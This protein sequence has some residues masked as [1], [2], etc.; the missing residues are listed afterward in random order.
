[1]GS[2]VTEQLPSRLFISYSRKNRAQVYPFAEALSA[3]GVGVWIDL[4][5][6]DP[7]DDFPVR[8]RE[9]IAQCHALLAWYSPEYSRSTYCQKEL[10]A[11]WICAQRLTRNALSRIL[12]INPADNVAHI[13]LGDLG[14]QNYLTAPKNVASQ[15]ATI[16]S[17]QE[18]LAG[19]SG[20]FA[21]V[22]EFEPPVW[23]PEV[24]QGSRRFVGR[25]REL[26]EIHT[27]FNS[28]G[29]SEHENANG[30]AQLQGLGGVGKTLLA[31]EYAKRFSAAYPGGIHWLR[32]YGF[33]PKKSI[34]TDLRESEYRIQLENI[35]LRYDI[36]IRDKEFREIRRDLG[37]KLASGAPYLWVVDDLPAGLNLQEA[38]ARWCA[39][40]PNGCTLMTTRTK[41]YDGIGS[42]ITVDVLDPE[43]ALELLTHERKAQTIREQEDAK[44]LVEAL[45]RHSLAL[46]VAGHFLLR[47]RSFAT[48]RREVTW[49]NETDPFGVL[50][51]SLKGQLPGGHEK[52]IVATLLASVRQ[53]SEEGLNL[54][55]LA[56]ELQAG[57]PIPLGLAKEVFQRA[58]PQQ[59][60]EDYLGRAVNQA[61]MHSLAAVSYGGA[62]G[63]ALSV[64]PLVRYTMRHGD[65]RQDE[66]L[67][68]RIKLREAAVSALVDLLDDVGDIRKHTRLTLEITHA[69]NLVPKPHTPDEARL[70]TRVARFEGERGNYSEA[71]AIESRVLP[72]HELLLGRDHPDTLITRYNIA[73]WTGD[74]RG[75]AEPLRQFRELLHDQQR[76]LGLD[77]A[78][79]LRTRS[80][81]AS[82]TARKG[83]AVEALRLFRE[84][85]PNQ[86]R[87][88]GYD[89]PDTL[90][91]RANIAIWIGH[92]GDRAEALRL[93]RE[94]LPDQE[95]V[96]GRDHPETLGTRA[97]IATWIGHTGDSAEALRQFRELLPDREQVLG[98]DHPDM[99]TTR[100]QIAHWAGET[101]EPVEALRQFRELLP[102]QERVLGCDHPDA[103]ATRHN[104][105][106]WTEHTGETSEA[107]RLFQELLPKRER[108]LGRDHPDT[109]RTLA[110][111]AYLTGATGE[112]AEGLRL[113]RELLP[114]QEQVR[115]YDHPDTLAIHN[116]IAALTLASGEAA[117]ALRLFRELL[118]IQ[119][120][121]LGRDHPDTLRTRNNIATSTVQT[122]DMAEAL[123]LS[124]ELLS[125]LE[126]VVGHTHPHALT[127]RNN[128]ATWTGQMGETAEALRL[129]R[130]LLPER[131]RVLGRDHPDTRTTRANIVSLE[132]RGSL[133]GGLD[134]YGK[135]SA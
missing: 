74:A 5:E 33:D 71:L 115:G 57:T 75:S 133:L 50:A 97:D 121:V 91:T 95:R 135:P 101:G 76:V 104:I 83:D 58:F 87:V 129:F 66:A 38:F 111:I 7:L 134:P 126:R 84:L 122:G 116:N 18:K 34:D 12:I 40:S 9:G 130:E 65:P 90:R 117:K 10:T 27:A 15:N 98:R 13:A 96:L 92:T 44:G 82:W 128:I 103:L 48:L 108:L 24:Q 14:K 55:R 80:D 89:H 107:L 49:G 88:L 51:E 105:A 35:A 124:R 54:L 131:E 67:V 26:W 113:F 81:I 36:P 53:L 63:D 3:A 32:A 118:P 86:E 46:D 20:D 8:I 85:L 41:D 73:V 123:R 42:T 17:I 37:R 21:A 72:I 60:A 110:N 47:T 78:V 22:R 1:M 132:Q 79:A 19:L 4:E 31:T 100:A 25:L 120:R 77:H 64:H 59:V 99:L 2:G 39:P 127:T 28:V 11:A 29:I 56:G 52:S 23:H 45:G 68:L 6:I 61:E 69:K 62:G 119:E 125:D 70:T 106:A 109:I 102:D 30:I 114:D 93:F 43:S 112:T 16:Q 94:L